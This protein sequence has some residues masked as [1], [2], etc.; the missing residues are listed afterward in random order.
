MLSLHT[1]TSSISSLQTL[2]TISSAE[3][4][5][6]GAVAT[7]LRVADAEDN[8][9]FWSIATTM[10]SDSSTTAA[11]RDTLGLGSAMVDT[12]YQGLS[13]AKDLVSAY[14]ARLLAAK[15]DGVDREKIQTELDQI[16][17]QIESV[18]DS[19]SF[20]GVNWLS[21]DLSM[22]LKDIGDRTT[23]ITASISRTASGISLGSMSVDLNALA[24]INTGGGGLLQKDSGELGD[25]GGFST[26]NV[27]GTGHNGH[28]DFAFTGPGTL[29]ASDTI[30]FDILVDDSPVEAG[31]LYTVVIDRARVDAALGV[32]VAGTISTVSDWEAV[33]DSAFTAQGIDARAGGFHWSSGPLEISSTETSGHPGSSITISNVVSTIGSN[34]AFG[35]E[36]GP[37]FEHDNMQATGTMSF[38]SAFTMPSNVTVMFDVGIGSGGP[39]TKT[40]DRDVVNTALGRSDATVSSAAELAQVIEFAASGS[41]LVAT[42]SGSMIEFT[43]DPAMYDIYGNNAAAVYVGNIRTS[44][45]Y[46]LTFDLADVD[47]TSSSADIDDYI[48]GVDYMLEQI[49]DAAA[50]L[51]AIQNRIDVQTTFIDASIDRMDAGVGRLVDADL[52]EESTR[53]KALET[54]KSLG[55]Q[56]LSI[57]NA[58]SSVISQLFR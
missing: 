12:A 36:A 16:Y 54:Q 17:K 32:G 11:V 25:I 2:R 23:S 51:G 26:V 24:L 20:S 57:A 42:A 52:E 7:G 58:S 3:E 19:A 1:N 31:D 10:R 6:Q 15:T 44:E 55:L 53:L 35:L 29:S 33:L 28:D 18:A 39:S 27:T 50:G 22:S 41:G 5:A 45:G 30:T 40:I 38:T 9:A 56:A 14:K 37:H 4:T 13:S 48:V 8:A 47:V 49:T 21:T 43:G 46:L 34:F